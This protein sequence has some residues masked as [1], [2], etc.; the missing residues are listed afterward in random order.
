MTHHTALRSFFVQALAALA[1]A[2]FVTA[3]QAGEFFE[4]EGVALR[5]YDA[6]AYVK[7]GKAV[8][9]S[10]QYKL[11]YKGSGFHF[12]SQAHRDAFAADPVK[13]APQY[14]GFCAFGIS[15]GYKAATD[16]AAFTVVNGKLYLNYNR[17]VQKQW[18]ADVPG[19]VALADK[20][21]P[22]ASK[23]A[24]VIE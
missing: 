17:D 7:D 1:A 3:V 5:G 6:V 20:Q 23:Q 18:S 10:P 8:K 15:K 11:E 14:G 24:K 9:G 4:K 16:P 21:W 19:F 12:S 13:Y 22:A 2:V